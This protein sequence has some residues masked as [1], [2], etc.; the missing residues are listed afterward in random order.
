MDKPIIDRMREVAGD[1]WEQAMTHPSI[2]EKHNQ[3]LEFL[4]T[5]AL[6]LALADLL[7]R[8][9]EGREGQL[10][11]MCNFLRSDDVLSEVARRI[12]LDSC[13]RYVPNVTGKLVDSIIAG[14]VEAAIGAIHEKAG[15]E[16]VR[17]FVEELLLTDDLLRKAREP[18]DPIMEL[19]ELVEA[20]RWTPVTKEFGRVVGEK[21]MFYHFIELNGRTVM[22]MGISKKKAEEKAARVMLS[23]IGDNKET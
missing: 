19:K 4:G 1:L 9:Y 20:K 8:R 18:H 15:Y 2:A 22:G 13:V 3:R 11:S 16:T 5:G 17:G 14:G 21:V 6:N 7:Y 23:I 12:G 10:S